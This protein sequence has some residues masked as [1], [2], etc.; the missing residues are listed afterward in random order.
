MRKVYF[1]CIGNTCRS[2]M[3][4]ELLNQK[5]KDSGLDDVRAE[6]F[7][8]SPF[9]PDSAEVK[10][11]REMAVLQVTGR[12]NGLKEHRPRGI[13]EIMFRKGDK[14]ALLDACSL[15]DLLSAIERNPSFWGKHVPIVIIDIDDPFGGGLEDYIDCCIELDKAIEKSL[16]LLT[17]GTCA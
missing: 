3:A 8:L 17:G 6:S 1:V 11:L 2:P 7:G 16:H 14:I 9:Y 12:I 13:E 4:A 10:R 5:L 15:S